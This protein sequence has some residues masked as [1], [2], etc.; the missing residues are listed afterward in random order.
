M[1]YFSTISD[2]YSDEGD[3]FDIHTPAQVWLKAQQKMDRM[4]EEQTC[5]FVFDSHYR[6][7]LW[8]ERPDSIFEFTK[9]EGQFHFRIRY[10]PKSWIEPLDALEGQF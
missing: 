4:Q 10:R 7:L 2:E 9:R 5:F 6:D 3:P 8:R 1:K